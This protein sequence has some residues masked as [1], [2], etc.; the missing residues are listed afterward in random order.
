MNPKEYDENNHQRSWDLLASDNKKALKLRIFTTEY[1]GSTPISVKSGNKGRDIRQR[2][3]LALQ[4]GRGEI[5]P[6]QIISS[7]G[8][9][10]ADK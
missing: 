1:E 5:T 4:D 3:G 8:L 6:Q 10:I 7:H 9:R 2:S